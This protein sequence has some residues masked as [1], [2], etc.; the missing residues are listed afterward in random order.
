MSTTGDR[1][2]QLEYSNLQPEMHNEEGRRAKAAKMLSVLEHFRGTADLAGATVVDLGCSTGFIADEFRRAGARVVGVDIDVPGLAAARARFDAGQTASFDLSAATAA[3]DRTVAGRPSGLGFVC[4]DGERL[5][6][7]SGSADVVVFN[8]IYEHVV[9]ADEVM[10]DIERVLAPD[11]VVY[12][13]L[14]NKWGVIEPHY[15]LP[16]LS[17]LPPK[18]ADAYMRRFGKGDAYH[19]RF[20]S[21]RGLR[22]MTGRLNVWDYTDT[23]LADPVGFAAQDV[24]PAPL[25]K[26]PTAAWRVGRP[27]MPTFIWVGTKGEQAPAGSPGKPAKV[28]PRRLAAR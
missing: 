23:V 2:A 1:S 7:P 3:E 11:G 8:H 24:V 5:P 15:G 9:D 12:L 20:R 6:L 10:T 19:E 27:L 13:G 21:E 18:A 25:D 4:A 17:W 22:K 28:P 16:F 14:G 26:L